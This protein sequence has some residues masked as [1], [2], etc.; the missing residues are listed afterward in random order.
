MVKIPSQLNTGP[1]GDPFTSAV[2]TW[3]DIYGEILIQMTN[4]YF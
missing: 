4:Q 1:D 2:H 3:S